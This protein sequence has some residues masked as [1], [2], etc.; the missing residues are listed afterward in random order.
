[1]IKINNILFFL[2]VCAAFSSCASGN[3]SLKNWGQIV[4]DSEIKKQFETYQVK[5]NLNYYISGSDVY[6]N[7]I[8]GLQKE[9]TLISTLWKKVE[10]TPAALRTIVTDM[11]FRALNI[12]QSQFGFVVLDNRGKQIGIW[13]SLLSATA[14]VRMKENKEVIIYTPDIDTYERYEENSPKHNINT[15]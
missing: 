8:L 2:I 7:A 13:Y 5:P 4:P 10:L 12:N 11:K 9:Y 6:P 1:M 3:V 14:P 15:R